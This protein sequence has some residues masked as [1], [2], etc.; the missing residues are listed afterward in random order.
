VFESPTPEQQL[1]LD[2][3]G[4]VYL[5]Y[6]KWPSW[7]WL[8]EKLER[9]NLNGYNV[10]SSF[11]HEA[12]VGYGPIF[13]LRSP[14]PGPQDQV[15]L[16]VAGLAHVPLA[17][18]LVVAILKLISNL[19]IYRNNIQLD[20]FDPDRPKAPRESVLGGGLE[21]SPH[22]FALPSLLGKEP[23]AYHCVFEPS[24]ESWQFV[25]LS[26]EVRRFAGVSTVDDYLERLSTLLGH[27][28]REDVQTYY[29]PF[30][31]PASADYLDAV[32]RNKFNESLVNPPGVERSARL[33]FTAANAEEADSGLSALAELL[34]GLKVPGI[35]GLNAGHPLERLAPY[36]E[37]T[38]APE[39]HDRIR[40]AVSLLDAARQ[41]RAGSQ[42]AAAQAQSIECF[43][44][45]GI[46]YP[47][48]DWPAAWTRIQIVAAH[49]FNS[50]REEIQAS[51]A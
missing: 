6:H 45:L 40:E 7:A 33:A 35:P 26:P 25:A 42:H 51:E 20:P 1:V 16:T 21:H 43:G 18:T 10:F 4:E 19:G 34:K 15:G 48:Y 3:I 13:P 32:W 44:R 28:K 22:L 29:S 27:I 49:A 2:W 47:V 36:L 39:T 11:V 14:G 5:K 9:K 41:I 24:L 12:S 23:S 31:L 30:T 17:D 37:T 50:I 46:S 8:E 38:L